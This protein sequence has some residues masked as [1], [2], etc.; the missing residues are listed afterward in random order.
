VGLRSEIGWPRV[1]ALESAMVNFIRSPCV[2]LE[3]TQR[4]CAVKKDLI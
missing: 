4:L 1:S 3:S 2:F